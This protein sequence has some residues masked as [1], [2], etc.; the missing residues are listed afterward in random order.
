MHCTMCIEYKVEKQNQPEVLRSA[1]LPDRPSGSEGRYSV[2]IIDAMSVVQT[3]TRTTTM[4]Y[5]SVL[6][7]LEKP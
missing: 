4:V 6:I 3:I 1:G 2:C 5:C 7:V